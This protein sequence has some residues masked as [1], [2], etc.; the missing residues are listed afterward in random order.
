MMYILGGLLLG[1]V[2]LAWTLRRSNG[3]TS[4]DELTA[5]HYMEEAHLYNSIHNNWHSGGM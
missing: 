2:G 1:I 3:L 5:K 4:R